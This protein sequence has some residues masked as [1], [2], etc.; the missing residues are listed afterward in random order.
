LIFSSGKSN[1]IDLYKEKYILKYEKEIGDNDR[2]FVY[3]IIN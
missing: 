2:D 1:N 3:D